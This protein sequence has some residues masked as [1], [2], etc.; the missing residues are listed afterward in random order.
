M[1][2]I[3]CTRYCHTVASVRH[4]SEDCVFPLYLLHQRCTPGPRPSYTSQVQQIGAALFANAC[5]SLTAAGSQLRRKRE[6][7]VFC[8]RVFLLSSRRRRLVRGRR[9]LV[10]GRCPQ[11]DGRE[12]CFLGSA[13]LFLQSSSFSAGFVNQIFDSESQT[14][15]TGNDERLSGCEER[16]ASGSSLVRHLSGR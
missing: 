8:D 12:Q 2:L 1:W 10:R 4:T 14:C 15:V 7:G 9:R 5:I 11:G 6:A 13:D 3:G 16:S